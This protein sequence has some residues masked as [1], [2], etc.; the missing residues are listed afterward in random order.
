MNQAA[1]NRRLT[2][3]YNTE[4]MDD[5]SPKFISKAQTSSAK[6]NLYLKAHELKEVSKI[7]EQVMLLP[8]DQRTAWV[9]ENGEILSE[10]V[11]IFVQDSNLT[12]EE[13]TM[14]TETLELSKELVLSL[15]DTMDIIQGILFDRQKLSS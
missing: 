13:V 12:L 11:D 1:S 10:A 9:E 6:F 5:Y 15:R 8:Q 4:T 7:L 14:D 2:V 3:I